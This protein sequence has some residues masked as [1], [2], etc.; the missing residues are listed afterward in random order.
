[1]PE[2]VDG[3]FKHDVTGP[4][5]QNTGVSQLDVNIDRVIGQSAAQSREVIE[6]REKDKQAVM[7][8]TGSKRHHLSKNPDS[9][10]RVL[11]PAARDVH[12]RANLINSLAMRRLHPPKTE[13]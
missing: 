13:E 1:M 11:E 12:A 8:A 6:S 3:V 9:T 7:R 5:P 10:Y 2:D 4:T